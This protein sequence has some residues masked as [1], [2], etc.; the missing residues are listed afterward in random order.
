M[1]L[2]HV[3]EDVVLTIFQITNI[4]SSAVREGKRVTPEEPLERDYCGSHDGEP[5][6]RQSRLS[7][8]KT[9][10][11]ETVKMARLASVVQT[12]MFWKYIPDTRNH[13]QDQSCGSDHPSNIT[14]LL[15]LVSSEA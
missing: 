12:G 2:Y 15:H 3:L 7:T 6:Q 8:S 14:S 1:L 10:I 11:E 5:N 4:F 13:K 9:G